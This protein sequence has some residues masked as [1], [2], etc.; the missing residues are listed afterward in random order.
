MVQKMWLFLWKVLI[1]SYW[2]FAGICTALGTMV[3]YTGETLLPVF[4]HTFA[5]P[6][7]FGYA[8]YSAF[9]ALLLPKVLSAVI[10]IKVKLQKLRQN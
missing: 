7:L 5:A 2:L 10:V 8:L 4:L 9:M 6:L 1:G 3:V